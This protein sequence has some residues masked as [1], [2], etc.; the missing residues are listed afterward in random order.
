MKKGFANETGDMIT[1][2]HLIR[3][4][5]AIESRMVA[6]LEVIIMTALAMGAQEDNETLAL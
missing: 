1:A 6:P 5:P 4:D 2:W 3:Q